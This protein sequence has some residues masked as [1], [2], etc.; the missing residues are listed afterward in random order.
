MVIYSLKST[1]EFTS[2][3]SASPESSLES[4]ILNGKLVGKE[5]IMHQYLLRSLTSKRLSNFHWLIK[6]APAKL[7]HTC[8]KC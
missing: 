2:P 8:N 4:L 5:N 6:E 1:K 7:G 3:F